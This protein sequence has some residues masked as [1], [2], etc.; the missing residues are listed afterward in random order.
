MT[1]SVE[2]HYGNEGIVSRIVQALE[3]AGLDR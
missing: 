2:K 3:E 1:E